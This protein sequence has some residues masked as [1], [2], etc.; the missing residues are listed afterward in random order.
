MKPWNEETTIAND[1]IRSVKF[2]FETS[3]GPGHVTAM[4][5][6]GVSIAQAKEQL[7]AAM[8]GLYDSIKIVRY[9]I[10]DVIPD[11]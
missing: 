10:L 8:T 2:Y 11:E 6:R 9:E 7:L 5:N 3:N 4:V 1:S